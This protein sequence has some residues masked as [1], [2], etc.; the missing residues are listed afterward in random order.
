MFLT[1][2]QAIKGELYAALEVLL[3]DGMVIG[4][5]GSGILGS[6]M[7]YD[8]TWWVRVALELKPS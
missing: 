6:P 4:S 2:I 5:E 1:N 3:G 7:A 8:F